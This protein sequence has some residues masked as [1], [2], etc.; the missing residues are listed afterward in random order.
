MQKCY[1]WRNEEMVTIRTVDLPEHKINPKTPWTNLMAVMLELQTE[2][3][4][5]PVWEEV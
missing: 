4:L 2:K 1:N 3:E 5:V